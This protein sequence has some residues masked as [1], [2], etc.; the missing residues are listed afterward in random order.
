MP[1]YSTWICLYGIPEVQQNTVQSFRLQN[2]LSNYYPSEKSLINI[3]LLL[4]S[5]KYDWNPAD[6]TVIKFLQA[7]FKDKLRD[8]NN[9][10]PYL[11]VNEEIEK[12][13]QVLMTEQEQYEY[14][15]EAEKAEGRAEGREEGREEGRAEGKAEGII[16][17]AVKLHMTDAG[18]LT[19]MLVDELL[20]TPEQAHEYIKKFL[21]DRSNDSEE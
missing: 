19:S 20:I 12:E 21:P 6:A 1:V 9:F 5:E 17:A 15:L 13:V 10:N 14:E 7:I 18:V 2:V 8:N 16:S 3:D 4:L 11:R